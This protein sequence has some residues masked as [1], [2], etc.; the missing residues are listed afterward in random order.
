M[1]TISRLIAA[2]LIAASCLALLATE[3][4]LGI[5]FISFL[6]V[7][8]VLTWALIACLRPKF[9][10]LITPRDRSP[11][12]DPEGLKR[13]IEHG[14][15]PEL[16]WIRKPNTSKQE[17]GGG[18]QDSCYRIDASGRRENPGHAGLPVH[19]ACYGDSFTFGRQVDDN[20]TFA[21]HLS[22]ITGSD[23]L[24]YGV[25]NYGLDQALLRVE[26]ERT[27][28]RD[29]SRV[30]VMGVVPSTIVRV[31]S[32]WKHYAE[33]GNTFGFKP[34]FFLCEE[35]LSQAP[36]PICSESEF[37]RYRDHL[38]EIQAHDP[39]YRGHFLR[40]MFRFPYLVST[41]ASPRRNLALLSRVLVDQ[42]AARAERR[43]FPAGMEIIME[44]NLSQRVNLFRE[45]EPVELLTRLVTRFADLGRLHDFDPVFF[46]LPQKDDILY[47]RRSG[48]YFYAEFLAQAAR[49]LPTVDLTPEFMHRSDLDA[50]YCDDTEYG[51]HLSSQG[52]LLA[53]EL[54]YLTL[55]RSDLIST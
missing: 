1:T 31:L 7:L 49:V 35:G 46:L 37:A 48:D 55:K 39:H 10:W 36:N 2:S 25:G 9:P 18:G 12:L 53:A 38:P 17:F 13:F 54:L 23:V 19:I 6:L 30:V 15:D 33:F 29:R 45:A 28:R 4:N 5:A 26:R 32:V 27:E 47:Q 11:D 50:L 22:E 44:C 40:Y 43:P 51:G 52:N 3:L 41:L 20:A 14:Y 34:R 8:E 16:G 42:L 24:N 21:W